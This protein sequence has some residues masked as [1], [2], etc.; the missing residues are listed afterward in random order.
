MTSS[1]VYTIQIGA[2]HAAL[3]LAPGTH[4]S[5]DPN[6]SAAVPGEIVALTFRNGVHKIGRLSTRPH[7]R[8]GEPVLTID[9]GAGGW[10]AFFDFAMVRVDRML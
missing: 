6:G 3:G 8:R 10:S 5:F 7:L 2:E 4:A 1:Q 9:D